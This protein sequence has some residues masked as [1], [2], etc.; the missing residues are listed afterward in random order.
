[1]LFGALAIVAVCAI[2]C[3]LIYAFA[4]HQLLAVVFGSKRAIA[5]NALLPL[6]A[7]FAVL[8]ATYLAVQY[9]LALKRKGFLIAIGAVAIVEPILLLQAAKRPAPFAAVVLLVQAIGA[10]LAFAI[11]LRRGKAPP[12]PQMAADRQA[13]PEP[14][15]VGSLEA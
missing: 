1:V 14:V 5:S 8:A 9:M 15:P 3:L 4:A 6:G 2:P 7:A 10:G 12:E 13:E 11:A